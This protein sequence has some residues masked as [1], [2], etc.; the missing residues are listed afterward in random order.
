MRLVELV[1]A[2]WTE[3]E[4]VLRTRALM[5]SIGQSPVVLKKELP[6]FVQPRV[7][8]AIIEECVKLVLV[9]INLQI[10]R[11]TLFSEVCCELRF[12]NVL[13]KYQT[14]SVSDEK[15]VHLFHQN[16]IVL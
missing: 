12:R 4:V 8:Y 10:F 13:P 6:G 14:G 2:P 11:G 1:P 15:L 5:D 9:K 16:C 7:Q 3:A